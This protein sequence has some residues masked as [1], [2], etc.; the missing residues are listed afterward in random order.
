MTHC[1]V[2]INNHRIDYV[3]TGSPQAETLVFAHGLGGNWR[4]WQAQL[5]YFSTDYHVIAFSTQGHGQSSKPS[6]SESYSIANYSKTCFGLLSSLGVSH[7]R[8]IGNSMGGVIG[9][10]LLN[11][12]PQL[13]DQLI[14]NGTTPR[15]TYGQLG[16]AF[17]RWTDRLTINLLGF[18]KYMAI[19]AKAVLA[20][21][22]DRHRLEKIFAE[23]SPKAIIASHQSL[24]NYDFLDTINHQTAKVIIIRTPDDK[25]INRSLNRALEQ[26]PLLPEVI[27][28][29]I[30]GHIINFQYPDRYNELLK[31]ILLLPLP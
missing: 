28:C 8:F 2:Q 9:Y 25:G 6:D 23:A 16:L 4:Q 30:G 22:N 3:E 19:A 1:S 17:M 31:R 10:H 7:C 18:D 14:T 29:P 26:L 21:P 24:G 12:H 15:L 11:N 27:D 5:D 20:K 13:I